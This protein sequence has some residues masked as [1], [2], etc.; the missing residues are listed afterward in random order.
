MRWVNNDKLIHLIGLA[1]SI[2]AAKRLREFGA[3][4]MA[5]DGEELIQV[6]T[7]Y[8]LWKSYTNS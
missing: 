5:P 2:A 1:P 6:R 4:W 3:V 8:S 7:L